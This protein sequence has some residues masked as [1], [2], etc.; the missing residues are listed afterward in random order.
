MLPCI[1]MGH[2]IMIEEWH[3]C[4]SRCHSGHFGFCPTRALFRCRVHKSA[5]WMECR[6]PQGFWGADVTMCQQ[7]GQREYFSFLSPWMGS[8]LLFFCVCV[9]KWARRPDGGGGGR[10]G[11]FFELGPTKEV[12]SL[13]YEDRVRDTTSSR[14]EEPLMMGLPLPTR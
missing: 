9:C 12:P 4:Y 11:G 2:I 7:F 14:V 6:M 1:A 8:L 13:R 5:K 3:I 10:R